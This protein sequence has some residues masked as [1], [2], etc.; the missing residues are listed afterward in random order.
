ME[1]AKIIESGFSVADAELPYVNMNGGDLVLKFKD[2]QENYIEVCFLDVV[3]FKWHM[4]EMLIDGEEHAK[5]H[6]IINSEWLAKHVEQEVIGAQE[7]YQHYKF[8]FNENGQLEVIS[9]GFEVKT[10]MY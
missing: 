8:N 1:Y 6:V 10:D 7:N 2:W 9:N 4:I 5:S 3:A